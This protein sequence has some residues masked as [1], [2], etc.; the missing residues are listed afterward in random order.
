[1]FPFPKCY[2]IGKFHKGRKNENPQF[3]SD[4]PEIFQAIV[5]FELKNLVNYMAFWALA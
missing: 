5:K 3:L 4:L 1:M 2:K